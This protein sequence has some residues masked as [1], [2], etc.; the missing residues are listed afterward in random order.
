MIA[1]EKKY[2]NLIL[3]LTAFEHKESGIS[4]HNMLEAINFAK[5]KGC[6]QFDFNGANSEIGAHDKDSY[7]GISRLYFQIELN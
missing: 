1:N 4:A 6:I 7:G 2:A 3:N 5:E